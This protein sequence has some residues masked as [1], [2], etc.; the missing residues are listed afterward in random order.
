MSEHKLKLV[1]VLQYSALN[2]KVNVVEL[3]TSQ[4]PED[5]TRQPLIRIY[6]NDECIFENPPF[7]PAEE[8]EEVEA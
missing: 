4:I 7:E 2:D 6:L 5:K 3:N 1:K 8:V